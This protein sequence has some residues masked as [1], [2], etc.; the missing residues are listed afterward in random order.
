MNDKTCAACGRTL[1]AR[2]LRQRIRAT[3]PRNAMRDRRPW[4]D[5][6]IDAAPRG[7]APLFRIHG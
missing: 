3:R 5:F 6:R 1:A 4:R 2:E 7:P